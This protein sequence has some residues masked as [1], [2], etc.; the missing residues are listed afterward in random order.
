MGVKL[1][2]PAV[3]TTPSAIKDSETNLL[4]G[5]IT[6]AKSSAACV[7]FKQ[8]YCV[9][10]RRS[11]GFTCKWQLPRKNA[12]P[13]LE[14]LASR[15]NTCNSGV[16]KKKSS[17]STNKEKGTTKTS[18]ALKTRFSFLV[19]RMIPVQVSHPCC[20]PF[21]QRRVIRP[22]KKEISRAEDPL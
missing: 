12:S 8:I 15:C 22:E 11:R 17:P 13:L 18:N 7:F 5:P 16:R 2:G 3:G 21:L 14:H 20:S 9:W 19:S 6:D 10:R 4:A 1:H